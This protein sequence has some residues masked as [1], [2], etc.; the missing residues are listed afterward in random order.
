ML[1]FSCKIYANTI[2]Y[3]KYNNKIN[4]LINWFNSKERF[5]FKEREA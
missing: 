1:S 4:I 2:I 5:I 3:N